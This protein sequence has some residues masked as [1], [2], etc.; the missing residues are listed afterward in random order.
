M[1]PSPPPPTTLELNFFSWHVDLSLPCLA[2]FFRWRTLR[3]DHRTQKSAGF[4]DGDFLNT[5]YDSLSASTRA[6][7]LRSG[8]PQAEAE[9]DAINSLIESLTRLS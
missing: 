6:T 8:A 5:S 4:I 3:T 7:L 1:L 9:P 2:F